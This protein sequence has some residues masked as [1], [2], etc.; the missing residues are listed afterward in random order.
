MRLTQSKFIA[1]R[2]LPI[3]LAGAY[4]GQKYAEIEGRATSSDSADPQCARSALPRAAATRSTSHNSEGRNHS[5]PF[6]GREGTRGQGQM[7]FQTRRRPEPV[8]GLP[9]T[10]VYRPNGPT[11][12]AIRVRPGIFC[13]I[14]NAL[15]SRKP[16]WDKG[17]TAAFPKV[18]IKLRSI[19]RLPP[20]PIRKYCCRNPENIIYARQ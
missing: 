14:T 2:Q 3:A 9:P 16:R 11:E 17:W 6:S 15:L 7:N 1:R 20:I 5:S 10:I 4:A 13:R 8:R 19:L 12:P 18:V